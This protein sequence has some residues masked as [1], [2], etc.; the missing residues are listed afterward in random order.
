MIGKVSC[1]AISIEAL[2]KTTPVNPP[3]VNR[4]KNPNANNKGVVYLKLPPYK[5]AQGS[6]F[7]HL[8][9]S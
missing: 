1:N 5:V 2:A 3:T 9:S 7:D 8:R 6:V 4:A